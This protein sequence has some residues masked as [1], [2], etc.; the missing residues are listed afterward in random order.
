MAL[1]IYGSCFVGFFV[2]CFNLHIWLAKCRVG[3]VRAFAIKYV[4]KPLSDVV[5]VD[6]IY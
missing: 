4:V 5:V 6:K 2:G 3:P 1:G